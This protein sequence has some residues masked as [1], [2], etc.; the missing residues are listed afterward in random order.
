MALV[1]GWGGNANDY[2]ICLDGVPVVTGTDATT[3]N[4]F[5]DAVLNIGLTGSKYFNGWIDEFRVSKGVARWTKP[6]SR[7][8][9][10]Y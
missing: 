2:A 5:V 4:A 9:G 3:V 10:P 6:F 7:P 1:R 8:V